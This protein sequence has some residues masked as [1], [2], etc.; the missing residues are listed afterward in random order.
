M[1]WLIFSEIWHNNHPCLTLRNKKLLER[2]DSNIS[3]K[4]V[5]WLIKGLS[6][7]VFWIAWIRFGD[8]I[9]KIHISDTYLKIPSIVKIKFATAILNQSSWISQIWTQIQIYW[10]Q[11]SSDTKPFINQLTILFAIF[12]SFFSDYFSFFGMRVKWL[13][14]HISEK[15]FDLW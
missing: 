12:E 3:N 15:K 14:C 9:F 1:N 10:I 11:E 7:A 2:E 4:T 6:S 8:K 5:I 13:M